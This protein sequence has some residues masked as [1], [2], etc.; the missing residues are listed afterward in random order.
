VTLPIGTLLNVVTVAIGTLLGVLL[1]DRL[2]Q[3]MRDTAMVVIGLVTLALGIQMTGATHNILL[4]LVS[5]LLGGM[6]GETFGIDEALNRLGKRIEALVTRRQAQTSDTMPRASIATAFV[7]A[8]LI[9]CVGPITVVGS[10]QDGLTGNYQLIAIKSLL[11][12]IASLTLASTLGW[13]VGLSTLTI[14]VVQG[15]ISLLA[16]L[17]GE[18]AVGLVAERTVRVGAT[19]LPLGGTMLDEMTA[20]GGI[21]MLG[22]ALLLLD[23]KRVPVANMLPAVALAPALVAV[24]YWLNVP[25]A[26]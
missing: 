15:G 26:P 18:H 24:L 16:Q 7:T 4:T 14:L 22:I 25:V 17:V 23:I 3:R 19:L 1:G 21:L 9:F 13:G 8:S 5:V 20:A 2:P 6:L 10:I 11:D 12:M